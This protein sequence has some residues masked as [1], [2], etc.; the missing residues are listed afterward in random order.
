MESLQICEHNTIELIRKSFVAFFE[1][2]IKKLFPM[3]LIFG[4]CFDFGTWFRTVP[5]KKLIF[6]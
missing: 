3:D 5:M 1:K 6:Y 2:D 4:N